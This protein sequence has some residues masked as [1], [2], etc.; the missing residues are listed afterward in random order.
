MA[1]LDEEAAMM[2]RLMI[3]AI[4]FLGFILNFASPAITLADGST[5]PSIAQGLCVGA[6]LD[7]SAA[8]QAE[9]TAQ[10]QA[11]NQNRQ[12]AGTADIW[13]GLCV[14]ASL[15]LSAAS[16]QSCVQQSTTATPNTTPP[17]T[18]PSST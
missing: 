2:K 11:Q 16:S 4:V 14:G 12:P 18:S 1:V 13:S 15:S 6:S 5:S 8:S 7:L 3:A 9:C 17:I 10:V